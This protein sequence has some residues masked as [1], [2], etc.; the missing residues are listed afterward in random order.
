MTL[1]LNI[2]GFLQRNL[3]P[4][5]VDVDWSDYF[6]ENGF[7]SPSSASKWLKNFVIWTSLLNPKSTISDEDD[8]FT[9]S[10]GSA[11]SEILTY[12]AGDLA[13]TAVG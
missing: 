5:G 9:S 2:A 12:L 7:L 3:F 1:Q 11:S 4:D 6:S 8:I 10:A 13:L